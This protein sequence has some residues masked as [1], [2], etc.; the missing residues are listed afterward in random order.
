MG[1]QLS[2]NFEDELEEQIRNQAIE[3]GR[4]ITNAMK[5]K[6]LSLIEDYYNKYI[7]VRYNRRG[8]L[9]DSFIE[10]LDDDG[11]SII[12]GIKISAD[13]MSMYE[14]KRKNGKVHTFSPQRLLDKYVIFGDNPP[15][16][17]YHGGDWHGGYGEKADTHI[18]QEMKAFR[19]EILNSMK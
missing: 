13:R 6:Y 12:A 14:E 16:F 3:C 15:Y 19:K 4:I 1:F 10:L 5:E 8:Q 18:Y 7:P 11:E 2:K 17:T 9:K